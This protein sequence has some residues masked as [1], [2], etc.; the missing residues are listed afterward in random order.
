MLARFPGA[1]TA[2]VKVA[3][4]G[5]TL[6]DDVDRVNAVRELVPTV[7]VDANG[8]W[9]VEEAVAGRRRPDRRRPAGVPR[10]TLRHRRRTRR[11]APAG[12]RA[13]RRRRK[14][15]QGRRPAGRGPRP[16][17]RHRGA[18]SRSAG[19]GF[20]TAGHRRA[21]RHPDRGLQRARFGGRDRGRADCRGGAAAA[22][23]TPAGWA[24]AGCSSKTSPRSPAPVDG[25]LAVGPV[26]PDPARLHALGAPP[27]RRQWWID[28]VKELLSA[29]CTVVRVTNLAYDD[30]GTGEPVVFIAGRGG[31]GR[32]WHPHQVPAF[33][34]AGYRCHHLR[35][36]RDRRHRKRRRASRRKPWSPTPR[37]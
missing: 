3:E 22:S 11:A 26:T 14:H 24:P 30:R 35:Q 16:R 20:G 23:V 34:A 8:G 4:P 18:E 13:D 9:S 15:P 28:R 27:E 7:R 12:R 36:P 29:A 31:A 25:N 32:T 1:R 2:K 10:T 33:L 17:R 6:A 21:D 19:R 37:R 5:Q